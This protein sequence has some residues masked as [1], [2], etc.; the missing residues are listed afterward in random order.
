[1]HYNSFLLN[2]FEVVDVEL[3]SILKTAN[4]SKIAF[5]LEFDLDYRDALNNIHKDFPVAPAQEQIHS[6]MLSEYQMC[7]LDHEDK[8]HLT[9]EKFVQRLLAKENYTF[10]HIILK[11]HVGLG[12]KITKVHR[13]LQFKQEKWLEP[14][15]SL[16]TR[17]QTQSKHNFEESF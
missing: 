4:D 10:K 8:G 7:R 13:T 12:F 14:C 15:I 5:V 9:T 1:M 17:T 2:D 11:L 3:S 6:N 16:N